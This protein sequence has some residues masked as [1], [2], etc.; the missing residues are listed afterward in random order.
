MSDVWQ[1][2]IVRIKSSDPDIKDFGT[3]FLIACD[4][5]PAY[6]LTCAHVVMDVGG[7]DRLV[8]SP[9]HARCAE[10][11]T[12]NSV[13]ATQIVSGAKYGIDIAVLRVEG[14][15]GCRVCALRGDR[16]SAGNAAI[17]RA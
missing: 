9:A 1:T 17:S 5:H 12:S 13:V 15:K 2:P 4:E 10:G 14:C 3:G 16:R 11:A 6:M 7:P 8:V